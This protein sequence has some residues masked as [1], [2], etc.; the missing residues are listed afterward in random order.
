[1]YSAASKG[2]EPSPARLGCCCAILRASCS[3]MQEW[4]STMR[5]EISM[6][7]TPGTGAHRLAPGVMPQQELQGAV[8]RQ[9]P[10]LTRSK[11]A[12]IT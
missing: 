5:G 2:E 11:Q 7:C 12:L 9:R 4:S 1:M 3:T 8:H 6:P 10:P